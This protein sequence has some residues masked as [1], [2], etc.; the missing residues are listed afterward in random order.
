MKNWGHRKG[1][2]GGKYEQ[3]HASIT[4]GV[5]KKQVNRKTE[6]K[7][8]REIQ[9]ES[10]RER[11]N[12]TWAKKSSGRKDEGRIGDERGNGDEER[13]HSNIVAEERSVEPVR[14]GRKDT[15]KQYL[16]SS[17]FRSEYRIG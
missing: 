13:P 6:R 9:R 10:G 8:Y 1:R 5:H 4:S 3:M 17:D 15:S 2:E 12:T 11:I 7:R 16:M 14:W